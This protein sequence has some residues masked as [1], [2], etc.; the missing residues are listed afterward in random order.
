[1]TLWR[2][3][4]HLD[5]LGIALD[6]GIG[7]VKRCS[8]VH[9]PFW[10]RFVFLIS[11][12]P[13]FLSIFPM[14]RFFSIAHGSRTAGPVICGSSALFLAPIHPLFK[15]VPVHVLASPVSPVSLS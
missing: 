2:P 1:M 9:G 5:A 3:G 10:L 13:Y 4:R 14:T 6:D 7:L 15:P 11:Y 8:R 12:S